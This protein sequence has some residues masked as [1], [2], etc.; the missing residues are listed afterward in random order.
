MADIDEMRAARELRQTVLQG[1]SEKNSKQHAAGKLTAR[2]RVNRLLDAGSFVET[3]T[4]LGKPMAES[5]V[6]TGYGTVS[7]RP[8]F[9]VAQDFTVHGGAMGEIQA[10]KTV[11]LLDLALSAGAPVVWLCDSAGVKVDEGARGMNAYARIY[12]KMAQLS[13]ICPMIAVLLG[14]VIGGAALISQLADITIQAKDVAE[15]MVYG[16]A[17][18]SALTGK[19]CTGKELGG[20]DAMASQGAVSLAVADEAQAI[21]ATVQV[22]S[23][24]PASSA[25]DAELLEG[26]DLNRV[27]GDTDP[28]DSDSLITGI[29]DGASVELCAAWGQE[30]RTLLTRIGGRSVGL[31]VSNAAVNE[32]ELAPDACVKAARFVR[33]CDAFSLPIVSLI[34]SRGIQVPD[35]GHQA[36]VIRAAAQLLYAYTSTTAPKVSV[37]V[38]SAIGQA[39][40]AMGGAQH[41]DITYAWPGATISALTPAAAVQVLHAKELRQ[42]TGDPNAVRAELESTYARDVA[43]G[44]CAAAD[45]M[46]NDIVNPAETRKYVIAALEM[47]AVKRVDMPLRKHGNMPL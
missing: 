12:A 13:G 16:P 32:G 11:K 46:I 38:G 24:L 23:Y 6:V 25:E 35:A 2:E 44:L 33:F 28:L 15:L 29:A 3:D 36:D 40:V 18:V 43:S 4:F 9:V 34:N 47:L 37:I 5:G 21:A 19:T 30:I 22:L 31:L 45:G 39:F 17:V 42:G 7:D 41:A 26:T 10:Q 14:P 8:V 27:M 1:D 20:A